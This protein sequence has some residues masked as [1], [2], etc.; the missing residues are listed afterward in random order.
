MSLKSAII[1]TGL[2]AIDW[3]RADLW[4]APVSR[5]TGIILMFHHVRPA[6]YGTFAP[7]RLLEITP[8][9]FETVVSMVREAGYEII[10]QDALPQRLR[11]KGGRPFALLTFDD[12]YRDNAEYALPILRRHAVPATFFITTPLAMATDASGRLELEEGDP[13]GARPG[14]LLSCTGVDFI[15][16]ARLD[17]EKGSIRLRNGTTYWRPAPAEWTR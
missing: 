11:E 13:Q 7:N 4:L 1:R 5:G 9:F 17:A 16:G 12:G 2:R 8:A 10:A 15:L 6:S 14:C 3:S